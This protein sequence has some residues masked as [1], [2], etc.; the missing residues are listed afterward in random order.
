MSYLRFTSFCLLF[1]LNSAVIAQR[2]NFHFQR[3]GIDDGLSQSTVRCILQDRKGFMWFGTANGLNRY[4]GYSLTIYKHNPMDSTSLS[5]D[6]ISALYEDNDGVL[7]VG[8][9]EGLNRF[10]VNHDNFTHYRHDPSDST[11]INGN[12]VSSIAQDQYGILWIGTNIGLHSF[13]PKTGAFK[14]YF[15]DTDKARHLGPIRALLLD[16]S[17]YTWIATGNGL[18]CLDRDKQQ[19][20]RY[21][22][23]SGNLRGISGNSITALCEDNTGTI[24]IGTENAGLNRFDKDTGQFTRY[25]H[26]LKNYASLSSNNINSIIE[27]NFGILWIGTNNGLNRLDAKRQSFKHY[28][29]SQADVRSLSHNTVLSIYEDRTGTLWIGTELGGLSNLNRFRD[30]FKHYKHDPTDPKSLTGNTVWSFCE[31]REGTLWVGTDEGLCQFDRSDESFKPLM[32]DDSGGLYLRIIEDNEGFLWAAR[33]RSLDKIDPKSKRVI[34]Y[35]YNSNDPQ[36]LSSDYV[37]S[38]YQDHQHVIW[39]GTSLG[40]NRFDRSTNTFKRYLFDPKDS[41]S[42]SG[43]SVTT[44]FEDHAGTLWIGTRNGLNRFNRSQDDFKQFK[45]ILHDPTSLSHNAVMNIYE[46]LNKQI[47]IGTYGGG[48]NRFNRETETFVRFTEEDGIPNN[49]I[50]GILDD[51]DG[52]LWLS[53]NNGLSKFNPI[54]KS[55]KNYD[56]ADGLQSNEFNQGAVYKTRASE[57]FFGGINGFNSFYPD[58]MKDNPYVPPIVITAFNKFDKRVKFN[59]PVSD[60]DVIELSYQ[61]NFFSF[62]FVALDYTLPAKNQYVY[63]LEGFDEDWVHSGLRRYASYT[64]LSPGD[65]VFRV[66]G[67]N[68]DQ[69]W[70]EVGASIAITITPPFWRTWWFYGLAVGLIVLLLVVSHEYRVRQRIA[71]MLELERVRV[72]E[73]ERIRKKAADDFHDEFGH[74]L[75]KIALLT[76]VMK[77]ELKEATAESVESMN[78]IIDTSKTLSIGMRD[79][80][81]TLNPER[82]SLYDVAVRIKDFGDELFERTG[83]AFRVNGLNQ[84]M[85]HLRLSM[86]WR[87]HLT[88]IFKEAMT[89]ILKHAQCHNVQLEFKLNYSGII[90]SLKDDGTG[91]NAHNGSA[92]QGLMSMHNRAQKINGFL[93]IQSGEHGTIVTFSG[94]LPTEFN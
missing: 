37:T 56:I 43:A 78:K 32:K 30:R 39:V 44:I 50:Y 65:Y 49:V 15:C 33:P 91:F 47:W 13:D 90:V 81:W 36:S 38:V 22:Y 1:V 79:F 89:N 51:N 29:Y 88:L 34:S 70:N 18:I 12:F 68:N 66:R 72:L 19:M 40:L 82:D 24:W 87:R 17:G 64:N 21:E 46:D 14:R 75:T 93:D 54:T 3:L 67:S 76:E 61:D 77:K 7:W 84:D 41:T 55:H 26:D 59:K 53:T 85:A 6:L 57:M 5:N 20:A 2:H 16:K 83:V 58:E 4:D 62:E 8:T 48:L 60:M 52:N 23:N 10:D 80:L 63:K 25:F 28:L 35:R 86:D 9:N 27:D 11:S 31:D 69:V 74:K 42:L 94:S 45:R 92:G 73:S 71:H